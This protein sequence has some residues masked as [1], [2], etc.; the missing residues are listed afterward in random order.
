MLATQIRKSIVGTARRHLSSASAGRRVSVSDSDVFVTSY[1]KSGNTWVRFLIANMLH[2]DGTTD[3]FNINQRVPDIY[4]LPDHKLL[5]IKSPRYLKSHEYFD[6]RYPQVLYIV[7]DVRS[8]VVSYYNHLQL[9]GSIAEDESIDDFVCRFLDGKVNRYGSW[10]E[11]VLS[12]VRVRDKDDSRFMLVRY[13]DL[14][15]NCVAEIE[16]IAA[17]LKVEK[18]QEELQAIA[19]L[20]SFSRMKTL[21]KSGIDKKML[22]KKHRNAKSGFVRSGGTS[23]WK[24]ALSSESLD[25]IT[26]DCGDLLGELGYL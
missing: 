3:F 8:V 18:T 7:R 22:S 5:E 17:F 13:E 1:P 14:K 19:D 4:T 26:R 24:Q 15:E 11:N 2:P 21:E 20:S 10:K 23:D 16:S 25:R 12:W 9:I 6:P